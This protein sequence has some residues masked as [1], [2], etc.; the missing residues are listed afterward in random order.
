M[1]GIR[2]LGFPVP[3]VFPYLMIFQ[4]YSRSNGVGSTL[5]NHQIWKKGAETLVLGETGVGL[6]PS[7]YFFGVG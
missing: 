3:D 5:K 4:S 1:L 7:I 6:F 2:K